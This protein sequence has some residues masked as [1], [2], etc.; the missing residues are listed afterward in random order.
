MYTKIFKQLS[1]KTKDLPRFYGTLPQWLGILGSRG[2][3]AFYYFKP[4]GP[5]SGQSPIVI[6]KTKTTV[7][8]YHPGN[9]T[10]QC[11]TNQ[12]DVDRDHK[13]ELAQLAAADS[14]ADNASSIPSPPPSVH[15]E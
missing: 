12:V 13:N 10:L 4:E 9:G 7:N 6:Y 8:Y 14:I 2:L 5:E 3:A 1:K 15:K 11:E